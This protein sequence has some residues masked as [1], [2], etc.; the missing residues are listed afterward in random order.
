MVLRYPEYSNTQESFDKLSSFLSTHRGEL[1]SSAESVDQSLD[2]ISANIRWRELFYEDIF[3]WVE[4]QEG[5]MEGQEGNM[6]G[7]EGNMEGQEG[8]MEG[9]EGNMEE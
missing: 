1:G 3:T 8:N 2:K 7:Q 6:K 9:Q 5:N 4:G